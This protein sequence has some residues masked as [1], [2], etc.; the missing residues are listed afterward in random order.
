MALFNLNDLFAA[1]WGYKPMNFTIEDADG[2]SNWVNTGDETQDITLNDRNIVNKKS[3]ERMYGSYYAKDAFGRD[4]FMPL[5]LGGELLPYT[6]L[7]IREQKNIIETPMT[8]RR[9]SVIEV[10][11]FD[12]IQIGV[13]G[14]CISPFH[15]YPEEEIE[16][17]HRL[18][19][20]AESLTCKSVITDIVL[21]NQKNGNSDKVVMRN[22]EILAT[23]GIEHVRAFQ[24][25][26]TSDQILELELA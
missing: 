20:R 19:Q 3:P 25:D 8:E 22:L 17:L 4:I 12:N 7:N 6:W 18:H 21:L 5:T 2:S 9:G 15:T 11:G 14:F 16:Q 13:K 10:I 26:L 24:F 1:T 23:Q